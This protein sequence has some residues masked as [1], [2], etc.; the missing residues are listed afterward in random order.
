MVI[1][2]PARNEKGIALIAVV[3]IIAV[4]AILSAA[5]VTFAKNQQ[6]NSIRQNK[7][8]QAYYIAD[9]GVVKAKAKI[10]EALANSL[11]PDL[12]Q[13]S[14]EISNKDRKSVV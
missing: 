2:N 13:I 11:T 4:V 6:I 5:A 12:T 9:A 8:M 1:K 3:G 14:N 10:N 7:Q